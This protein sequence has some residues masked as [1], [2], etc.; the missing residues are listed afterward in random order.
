MSTTTTDAAKTKQ[1]STV[2]VSIQ[3]LLDHAK[4]LNPPLRWTVTK[5][6]PAAPNVGDEP[7]QKIVENVEKQP[8]IGKAIAVVIDQFIQR[9]VDKYGDSLM[10][11]PMQFTKR[12]KERSFF[13]LR[14]NVVSERLR[15]AY[16]SAT[17]SNCRRFT[18]TICVVISGALQ[19]AFADCE[20]RKSPAVS[21]SYV[22]AILKFYDQFS[23]FPHASEEP[24]SD[25]EAS[26]F[27]HVAPTKPRGPQNRKRSHAESA[28]DDDHAAEDDD[29]EDGR[30][31]PSPPQQAQTLPPPPKKKRLL[32]KLKVSAAAPVPKKK[33][34]VV[35]V[36]T[37]EFDDDDDFTAGG[38]EDPIEDE[39]GYYE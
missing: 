33:A 11:I 5:K 14:S 35:E 28:E 4:T 1:R 34:A 27:K 15:K 17:A 10:T 37:P 30:T 19:S 20:R 6:A 31:P 13:R 39:G 38:G 3:P 2:F 25:E 32:Q 24:T 23:L 12:A 29:N 7:Q 8:K 26:L 18:S 36:V 22:E 16:P 9:W 21:S